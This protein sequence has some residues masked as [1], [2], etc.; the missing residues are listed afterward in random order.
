MDSIDDFCPKRGP[1]LRHTQNSRTHPD[2]R[3]VHCNQPL[4]RP[5]NDEK[6]LGFNPPDTG[7]GQD[8]P[9]G[10]DGQDLPFSV[11]RR[12][13]ALGL[14]DENGRPIP[15]VRKV[16]ETGNEDIRVINLHEPKLALGGPVGPAWGRG[17]SWRG[18]GALNP[19]DI[20]RLAWVA[21]RTKLLSDGG[22]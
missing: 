6:P 3:C 10:D 5:T 8:W 20:P 14:I 21:F 18:D 19:R 13:H 11:A 4:R 9:E 17:R 1:A 12:L 15:V 7:S 22:S 16:E 2:G